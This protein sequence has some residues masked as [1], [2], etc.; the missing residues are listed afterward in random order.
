MFVTAYSPPVASAK[1]ESS[2]KEIDPLNLFII[3]FSF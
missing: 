2:K 1:K 3:I